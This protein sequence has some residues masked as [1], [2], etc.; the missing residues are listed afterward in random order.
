MRRSS[1]GALTGAS[2]R[3]RGRRS[4]G[5]G[6]SPDGAGRRSRSRTLPAR[7]GRQ[8]GSGRNRGDGRTAVVG[9][10]ARGH[11]A[12]DRPVVPDRLV[13]EG[14]RGLVGVGLCDERHEPAGRTPRHLCLVRRPAHELVVELDVVAHARL[15][16]GVD[17]PVVA[18]PRPELF[19][20]RSDISARKPKSRIPNL[21]PASISR[22][23]SARS[24]SGVTQIS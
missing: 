5:A 17:R 19:S 24:Y 13:A 1:S 23:K 15:K 2:L 11:P 4:G 20:S 6:A 9:V 10:A 12:D 22:S 18:E 8:A 16:R 14:V 21:R 7:P 3:P